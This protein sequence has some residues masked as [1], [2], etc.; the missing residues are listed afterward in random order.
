M[1]SARII[2]PS[3]PGPGIKSGKKIDGPLINFTVLL[4]WRTA[5][6]LASRSALSMSSL[7]PFAV[8]FGFGALIIFTDPSAVFA[9]LA[10]PR[11]LSQ[12]WWEVC[13]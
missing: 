7:L 1:L 3:T 13:Q 11:T 6:P 10:L 8:R 9:V 4:L 5:L 12:Q 2:I